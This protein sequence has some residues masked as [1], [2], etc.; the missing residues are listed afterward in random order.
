MRVMMGMKTMVGPLPYLA[1]GMLLSAVA[2]QAAP[3]AYIT[4]LFS[5]NVSVIDTASNTVVATVGVGSQPDG[6]AVNPAGTRV[7]VADAESDDVAVSDTA[8]ETVV[9]T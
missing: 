4:N 7:Y 1:M 9:A 6:V 5:D 2:A 3:F 8:S